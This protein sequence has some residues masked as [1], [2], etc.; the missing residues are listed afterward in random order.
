MKRF[1]A[2]ILFSL[3]F[4]SFFSVWGQSRRNGI[5]IQAGYQAKY[6]NPRS[7]NFIIGKYNSAAG[8]STRMEEISWANGFSAGLGYH[9]GRASFRLSGMLFDAQT[10]GIGTDANGGSFRRDV[11]LNGSVISAGINSELIKFYSEGG[12]NVGGSFD[13]SNFRTS[14]SQVAAAEYDENASLDPV[15]NA[16]A[17]SFTILTPFRFGIGPV[18]KFSIEPYYQIF[19]GRLNYRQL[20]LEL[21]GSAVPANSPELATEPD[22]FGVNATLMILLRRR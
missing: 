8:L 12:F 18:V 22:H 20:N 21:N 7:V 1:Y 15:S 10:Y 6:L 2:I 17:A 5:S 11:R 16:W 4:L 14:S 13:L 9:S 3:L 19:F